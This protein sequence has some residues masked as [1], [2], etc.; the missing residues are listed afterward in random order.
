MHIISTNYTKYSFERREKNKVERDKQHSRKT[1]EKK[2]HTDFSNMFIIFDR[3][4]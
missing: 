1:Q 2:R 3:N 4:S